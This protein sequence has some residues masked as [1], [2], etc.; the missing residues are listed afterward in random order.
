MRFVVAK[1]RKTFSWEIVLVAL[2]METKKGKKIIYFVYNIAGGIAFD[3][4]YQQ[5]HPIYVE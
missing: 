2:R 5:K 3:F 1:I 4:E